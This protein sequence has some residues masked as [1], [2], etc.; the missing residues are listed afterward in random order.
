MY[1]KCR[2]SFPIWRSSCHPISRLITDEMPT[3]T[4]L[5]IYFTLVNAICIHHCRNKSVLCSNAFTST[6]LR[7]WYSHKLQHVFQILDCIS[8][9]V[10]KIKLRYTYKYCFILYVHLAFV[11]HIPFGMSVCVCVCLCVARSCYFSEVVMTKLVCMRYLRN[12]SRDSEQYSVD[13]K[14]KTHTIMFT[15]RQLSH[16]KFCFQI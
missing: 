8:N 16:R 11:V 10:C 14:W 12:I 2:R 15:H 7:I 1:M 4:V 13:T 9:I 3:F 6:T 5:N